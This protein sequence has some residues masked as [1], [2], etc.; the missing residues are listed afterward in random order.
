MLD[1]GLQ[2]KERGEGKEEERD[3]TAASAMIP[4]MAVWATGRVRD[5]ASS[6]S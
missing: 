2:E 6:A 4:G 3:A 5:G 1:L